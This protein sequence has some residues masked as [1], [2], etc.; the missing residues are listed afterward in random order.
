MAPG[1]HPV[2]E[3]NTREL[4]HLSS[5]FKSHK[6]FGWTR[7]VRETSWQEGH[8]DGDEE[9]TWASLAAKAQGAGRE[10]QGEASRMGESRN[11]NIPVGEFPCARGWPAGS[12]SSGCRWEGG[13]GCKAEEE[14]YTED[15]VQRFCCVPSVG[16]VCAAGPPVYVC[17]LECLCV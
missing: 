4:V 6:C 1:P 3:V 7:P 16:R 2:Y 10:N 11:T 15:G 12:P 8:V 9:A 13:Q 14:T 17:T 5:C